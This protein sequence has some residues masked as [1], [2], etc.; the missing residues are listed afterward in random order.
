MEKQMKRIIATVLA[1]ITLLGVLALTSCGKNDVPDGMQVVKGG[2]DVGYYFYGPE[3]WVV[4][5]YGE[6]GCTYVSK[7]DMSS[8]TFV[9][10]EKPAGTVAEYFESEKVK[11]PYEITVSVNG[12]E[13]NFGN[14]Y[15]AKKYVYTYTY[16][17]FS[18]TCM[19]IFVTHGERFFIFTY[20]ANNSKRN[21]GDLSYYEY[22]LEKVQATIEAFRIVDKSATTAA[23]EYEK[24]TEGYKLISDKDLAGFK[25]YVPDSFHVDHSSALV[26]ATHADGS[27]VSMS[28][29]TYTEVSSEAYWEARKKNIEAYADKVPEGE[30]GAL[31]S[32]VKQIGDE[33]TQLKL[34]D[35]KWA[36]AYEYTYV[37]DGVTYHV[38]QVHIVQSMTDGYVFTYMAKEENY[39]THLAEIEKVLNKI[40]Y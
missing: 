23:P 20:T 12:D 28:R 32:S 37:Y 30:G 25:L 11:F 22:Y 18:Y 29:S 2:E 14:A 8:M 7:I 34:A 31:V 38:Y 26:S 36:L 19:Q 9:E 13:C 33:P 4:A 6:I 15:S 39:Q 3:E 16:K 5:N 24:D 17:E 1:L 21:G 10:T 27:T 35:T 40:T